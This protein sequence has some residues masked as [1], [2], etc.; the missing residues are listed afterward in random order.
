MN[1]MNVYEPVW[2][3]Y[4]PVIAIK[5]KK[6]IKNNA[7]EELLLDRIDFEKAA[8][9]KNT[10]YQFSVELNEGR[11]QN[12]NKVSMPGRDFVRAINENETMKALVKT[13]AFKFSMGNKFVLTIEKITP[14]F[15]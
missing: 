9:K 8:V 1:E 11:L 7:A 10:A 14:N 5:L 3:K 13:D 15:N 6:A 12:S 2:K 4:F